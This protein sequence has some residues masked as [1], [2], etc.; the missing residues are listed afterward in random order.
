MTVN[1]HWKTIPTQYVVLLRRDGK[2]VHRYRTF[3]PP[4]PVINHPVDFRIRDP[5]PMVPSHWTLSYA[6]FIRAFVRR[7]ELT[8]MHSP[9]PGI[10]MCVADYIGLE[11]MHALMSPSEKKL[12][13][14]RFPL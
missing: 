7:Y 12:D 2:V 9:E 1:R 13:P 10:V 5:R 4:G 3:D 6:C 14:A 8:S 11:R